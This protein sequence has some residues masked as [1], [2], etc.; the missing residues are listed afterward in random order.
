MSPSLRFVTGNLMFDDGN[1]RMR[2]SGSLTSFGKLM[3][4]NTRLGKMSSKAAR[5]VQHLYFAGDMTL[6][7][8]IVRSASQGFLKSA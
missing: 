2:H 8:N 6:K 3:L 4:G 5:C 7:Y 1:V